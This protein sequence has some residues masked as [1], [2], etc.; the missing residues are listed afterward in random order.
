VTCRS[1]R[2]VFTLIELLVVIA[3]IAILASMLLP[4]L[5]KARGKARQTQCRGNLKQVMFAT[6]M[7]AGDNDDTYPGYYSQL[8]AP[9]AWPLKQWSHD[10]LT[11]AGD[12]NVFQC[13][14]ANKVKENGGDGS[15]PVTTIYVS[16]E[17]NDYVLRGGRTSYDSKMMPVTA[18][19]STIAIYDAINAGRYCGHR[20][21]TNPTST[22][23]ARPAGKGGNG[24]DYSVHD[25]SANIAFCD[26]HVETL[27]NGNW[28]GLDTGNYDKYWKRTR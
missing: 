27:L 22:C 28:E 14:T 24:V 15:H 19:S 4:A 6:I 20:W 2:R 1:P 13:P 26:G 12:V 10:V 21:G 8:N 5:S 7:Y 25:G 23:Y 3:I 9:A 18:P 17:V 16:Y 11:Y